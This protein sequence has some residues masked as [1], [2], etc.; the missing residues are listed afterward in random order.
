MAEAGGVLTGNGELLLVLLLR[1]EAL[2]LWTVV[3]R[4]RNR[5]R[6][7]SSCVESPGYLPSSL[8]DLTLDL[9]PINTR[10]SCKTVRD[11]IVCS[12]VFSEH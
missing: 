9:G 12:C 1:Q 3:H 4:K 7:R 2:A 10:T 11:A 8:D 6:T 5:F